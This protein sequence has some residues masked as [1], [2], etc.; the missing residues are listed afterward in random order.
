MTNDTPLFLFRLTIA[1]IIVLLLWLATKIFRK[2]KQKEQARLAQAEKQQITTQPTGHLPPNYFDELKKVPD[3]PKANFPFTILAAHKETFD[4]AAIE[5]LVATF[6]LTRSPNHIY[7]R[8][9][10]S[11]SNVLFSVL[12]AQ[13]PGTF[14]EKLELMTPTTGIMLIM[15]LPTSYDAT[16]SCENFIAHAKE[17]AAHLNGRLLDFNQHS[18]GEKELAN[19]RHA[20]EIFQQNYEQWLKTPH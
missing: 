20:A 3:A 1:L 6:Q 14:P 13:R 4:G 16:E 17:I 2:A 19:Y 11:G 10:D 9:D 8:L 12:N 15:Q 18:V 5:D 7:E